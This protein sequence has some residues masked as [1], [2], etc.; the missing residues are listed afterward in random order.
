LNSSN[1]EM[2]LK[3]LALVLLQGVWAAVAGTVVE[4]AQLRCGWFDNPSPGNAWFTDRE[5]EWLVGNQ[6]GYQALGIWPS[7]KPRQWV[8]TNR[9]YGYG[10]TC[11]RVQ[12]DPENQVVT[13]ILSTSSRD[14]SDCRKDS[15]L[16][17][18]NPVK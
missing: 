8:R 2:S 14:L 9:Y 1:H 3:L 17:E 13:R 16:K 12:I 15:A 10:C 5:G 4:S 11:M 7:F 6:G 18:P